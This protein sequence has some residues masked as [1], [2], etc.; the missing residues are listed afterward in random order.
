MDRGSAGGREVLGSERTVR[1]VAGMIYSSAHMEYSLDGTR[2]SFAQ[3]IYSLAQMKYAIERSVSGLR[4]LLDILLPPDLPRLRAIMIKPALNLS[5]HPSR[6]IRGN[7]TSEDTIS[8]NR[9][10]GQTLCGGRS[11]GRID[12]DD[13]N[14]MAK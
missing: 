4:F 8:Q 13:G 5:P 6:H 2:Y 10:P 7:S 3:T 14:G 12:G 9:R 11:L 1:A